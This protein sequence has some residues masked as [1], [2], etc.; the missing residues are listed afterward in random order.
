M[1]DFV[2][3]LK[4]FCEVHLYIEFNGKMYL[5]ICF[6]KKQR[7][8]WSVLSIYKESSIYLEDVFQHWYDFRFRVSSKTILFL[9]RF[10]GHRTHRTDRSKRINFSVCVH[11]IGTV[12]I[13]DASIRRI[14]SMTK[15]TDVT[16]RLTSRK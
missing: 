4:G 1:N 12:R 8:D 5:I 16:T 14:F 3:A 10:I 15:W 7:R 13:A 2:V 9:W 6:Y 11:C